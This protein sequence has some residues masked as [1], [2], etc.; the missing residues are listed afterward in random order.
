M[1]PEEN[2]KRLYLP[3]QDQP[4]LLQVMMSEAVSPSEFYVHLVTPEAVLLAELTTDLDSYYKSMYHK[5]ERFV[6]DLSYTICRT[7][8]ILCAPF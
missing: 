4:L 5:T 7:Q 8:S 6:C 1:C 3:S 2:K